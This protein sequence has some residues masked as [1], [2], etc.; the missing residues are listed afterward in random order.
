MVRSSEP[1]TINALPETKTDITHV[2]PFTVVRLSDGID[3]AH[4]ISKCRFDDEY[5][6]PKGIEIAKKRAERC[7][8]KKKQGVL[9]TSK[10]AG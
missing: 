1:N 8:Q 5:D 7:L 4:G 9:I 6:R 2:G 3:E 10:F